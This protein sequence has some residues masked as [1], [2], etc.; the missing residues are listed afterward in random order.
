MEQQPKRNSSGNVPPTGGGNEEPEKKKTGLNIYW[1]YGLIFLAVIAYSLYGSVNSAGVETDQQRF[2]EMVRQGDVDT[3]KTIRNQKLLKVFVKK[4]SMVQKAA[5]YKS[6]L[7]TP[8]DAKRYDAALRLSSP[9]LYFNVIDDK[10]FATQLADFYKANPGIKQV[11]DIPENE[12]EYFAQILSTLLPII[13]IALV[14][15]MI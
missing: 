8:S 3:I 5:L 7:N 14:F 12:G 4:D 9:Q 1:I 13:L 15:I 10:T 6:L 2:F 11:T